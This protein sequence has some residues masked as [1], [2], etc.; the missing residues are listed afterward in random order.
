MYLIILLTLTLSLPPYKRQDVFHR[1]KSEGLDAA[2]FL[3]RTLGSPSSTNF[4]S[5]VKGN[6]LIKFPITVSDIDRDNAIYGPQVAILKGKFVHKRP[7]HVE[8]SQIPT[9]V[10]NK[11]VVK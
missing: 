2:R 8:N 5:I 1:F 9:S 6:Q 10:T 11:K 4:K 7:G 3:Q